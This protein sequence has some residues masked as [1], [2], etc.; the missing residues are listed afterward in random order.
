LKRIRIFVCV[1]QS[2]RGHA[3]CAAQGSP[4][5]IDALREE[6]A[7]LG[8][9]AERVDIV[10]CGCLDACEKGPVVVAVGGKAAL[11]SR[12]PKGFLKKLPCR[13]RM[14]FTHVRAEDARRIAEQAAKAAAG[15]ASVE[16]S[17]R[18]FE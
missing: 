5:L 8:G 1:K 6:L 4:R 17:T 11:E 3:C 18:D 7:Q 10:S 13:P 16:P 15:R 12:P 14:E 9:V 2:R